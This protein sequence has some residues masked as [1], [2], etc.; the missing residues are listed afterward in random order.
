MDLSHWDFAER[1]TGWEAAA[2]I[3]GIEPLGCGDLEYRV[4]VVAERLEHDYGR[5]LHHR[6]DEVLEVTSP[7]RHDEL[8]G[9]TPNDILPSV[10]LDRLADAAVSQVDEITFEE[11]RSDKRQTRFENQV[12]DRRVIAKWL[13]ATG[14]PSVYQFE[15]SGSGTEPLKTAAAE[16][17]LDPSDLPPELDAA[18]L[19]FR[20]V[21]NGYGKAATFRNKLIEYLEEHYPSFGPEA[22]TRIATVANPDKTTGRKGK[23][24]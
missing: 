4:R 9:P 16:T 5:A 11:W 8:S 23:R 14:L 6:H 18:M 1:F 7:F 3:L 24:D 20:A 19:A 17:D 12:F 2:L 10:E 15:R 22:V 13:K 21:T